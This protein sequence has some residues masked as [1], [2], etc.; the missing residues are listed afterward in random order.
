M[1]KSSK[2]LK[3]EAHIRETIS[4]ISFGDKR[5]IK[6]YEDHIFNLPDKEFNEL[7]DRLISGDEI[8]NFV[9]PIHEMNVPI[10]TLIK[11]AESKGVK[12]HHHIRIVDPDI[13]VEVVSPKED[14]VL[15]CPVRRT[16]H[17]SSKKLSVVD[18]HKYDNVTG[19][20]TASSAK[21]KI[22]FS[23]MMI[24][25]GHN[26]NY[27]IHEFAAVRGGDRGLAL[28]HEKSL[29]LHG[30]SSQDAIEKYGDGFQVNRTIVFY[31]KG[32]GLVS[33]L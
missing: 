27:P 33:D 20:M 21:A 9:M 14:K 22:T 28:A 11:T 12:I 19:Q 16:T 23:E 26:Q 3:Q 18:S 13:D 32:M 2:R 10:A 31:L 8:L 15:L 7:I 6:L 1:A 24:L 29:R 25:S 5:N 4:T 30:V 17:T